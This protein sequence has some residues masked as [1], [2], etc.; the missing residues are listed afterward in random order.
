MVEREKVEFKKS[1]NEIIQSGRAVAA[2][3]KHL[4]IKTKFTNS[5]A[6]K[7]ANMAHD[8]HEREGVMPSELMLAKWVRELLIPSDKEVSTIAFILNYS[9]S[10]PDAYRDL[11]R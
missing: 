10:N 5:D 6:K 9:W 8:F 2:Q 4:K 3:L 11:R 1:N 7:L